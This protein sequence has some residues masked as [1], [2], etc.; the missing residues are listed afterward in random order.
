MPDHDRDP[1]PADDAVP[2]GAGGLTDQTGDP[3]RSP[4][5]G[6]EPAPSVGDLPAPR[7]TAAGG[8]TTDGAGTADSG[9]TGSGTTAGGG[10]SPDDPPNS[11]TTAAT[12][13]PSR[14]SVGAMNADPTIDHAAAQPAS[15]EPNPTAPEATDPGVM[16][17]DD[18]PPVGSSP[19]SATGAILSQEDTA[20]PTDPDGPDESDADGMGPADAPRDD[21][22][23]ASPGP[24]NAPPLG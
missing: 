20:N 14:G 22:L 23:A 9:T 2:E 1:I 24:G 16:P 15:A 21:G 13:A 12:D 5:S 10:T 7:A 18:T 3:G 17:R 19:A 8:G 6:A 11:R 4:Q